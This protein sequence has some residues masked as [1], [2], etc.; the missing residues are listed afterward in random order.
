MNL[1]IASRPRQLHPGW[2]LLLPLLALTFYLYAPPERRMVTALIAA[3]VYAFM[4][5][6][7]PKCRPRVT[8]YLC[9]VNIALFLMFLK[10]IAVPCLIM[11]VGAESKILT[12]LPS[13]KSME[14]AIQIDILAYIAFCVGLT[15]A[16]EEI[17][18]PSSAMLTSALSQSPSGRIVLIF[19][20]LGIVGFAAAFGSPTRIVQYF[21]EP[22]AVVDI[23]Q[24]LDGTLFGLLG[25]I[26]RPFL[27]FS[28]VAWWSRISDRMEENGSIWW[29]TLV[30]LI[31]AL[32][33]TIANLTFSF[34]RAA[35]VFP[36]ICLAATYSARIRL[37]PI[38]FTIIVAAA[39][40]PG[41]MAISTYRSNLM[42]GAEGNS[43]SATVAETLRET[44]ETIQAYSG[45]PQFA[46]LFYDRLGWGNTLY[47]GSTLIAS[48][49][50]PVPI[51]GKG[52][53]DNNGPAIF[54]RAIYGAA[55]F[56]DQIIPFD[57]ELFANFHAPGVLLGFVLLGLVLSYA[58]R[59][60]AAAQSTFAAFSIQYA[61]LW[62]AMLAAWSLSI[63]SQILIYFFVP[64]YFYLATLQ[65][66]KWILG[67]DRAARPLGATR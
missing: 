21:L 40:L 55:G 20:G 64:I 32:G 3:P 30:G 5:F 10:L 26:L 42:A 47:G 66:R 39:A 65:L 2:T 28:L 35:F 33:I 51:V 50:G 16:S 27:A 43:G 63:F 7:L 8:H 23:Q 37:I 67:F 13:F 1:S 38:G 22:S 34:N 4:Q 31:A 41:L 54:N 11:A 14:G 36:L 48:A 61:S 15:L 12:A 52:F 57:A 19:A 45:G 53:R 17:I 49:L 44:S 58:Q 24:E 9:P 6:V 25:T 29:P 62:A 59:L 46:A 18:R 56:E 60:F